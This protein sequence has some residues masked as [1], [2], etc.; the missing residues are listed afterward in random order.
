MPGINGRNV[1]AKSN[2]NVMDST[3]MDMKPDLRHECSQLPT[4]FGFLVFQSSV[5]KLTQSPLKHHT[6]VFVGGCSATHAIAL[7]TNTR[8]NRDWRTTGHSFH[9]ATTNPFVA[10]QVEFYYFSGLSFMSFLVH[11]NVCMV[12]RAKG[13]TKE[14]PKYIFYYY[15]RLCYLCIGQPNDFYF[16]GSCAMWKLQSVSFRL[17]ECAIFSTHMW[18]CTLLR[19]LNT[20]F[21]LVSL[22][23]LSVA[24]L[25]L[26]LIVAIIQFLSSFSRFV[27]VLFV[28]KHLCDVFHH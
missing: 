3:A 16:S 24:V 8:A 15:L 20:G 23:F 6:L 14:T 19:L 21:Q 22:H 17:C 9:S 5:T 7:H 10:V 26:T 28:H 11:T 13:I 4:T 2:E 25:N 27:W 1:V 18:L 12:W